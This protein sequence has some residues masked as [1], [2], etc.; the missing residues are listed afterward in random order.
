[1]SNKW[2]NFFNALIEVCEEYNRIKEKAEEKKAEKADEI[3]QREF[4]SDIFAEPVCDKSAVVDAMAA[5]G[6]SSWDMKQVLRY[7]ST[8]EQCK[9]AIELINR[10]Y[11]W[12]NVKDIVRSME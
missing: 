12:F 5:R 3:E 10:D 4:F 1:M 11:D 8:T 2:N 9:T 6:W 7:C